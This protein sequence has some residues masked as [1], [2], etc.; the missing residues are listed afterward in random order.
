MGI[1]SN[2]KREI[3]PNLV[4]LR[5][6]EYSQELHSNSFA[7]KLDRC[8][9]SC[10]IHVPNKTKDLNIHVFSMIAGMNDSKI[11]TNYIF[12]ECECKFDER[13][14]NSNQKWNIDE[15]RC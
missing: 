8:V 6:N 3:Q 12:C 10:N 2:Q 13:K 14:C 9:G 4:N 15:C 7:I 5:P 11:L 1:L